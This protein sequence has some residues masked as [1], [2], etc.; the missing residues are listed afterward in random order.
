[1]GKY[2]VVHQTAAGTNLTII[3]LTGSAAIRPK[4]NH[5]V[6]GSDATPADVATE[7]NLSRTSAAGTGGTA[8]T[9]AP[10]DPLTVAATAAGL[11]GTFTAEPTYGNV[12]LMIPLNQRA[13]YQWWAMPGFEPIAAAV[14]ANGFGLRSINSGGTPNINSTIVWEE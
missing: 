7:F 5:I 1:M 12:I 11:G 10:L 3:L 2:A 9:A 4:M 13:T 6:I 14:A 8:L